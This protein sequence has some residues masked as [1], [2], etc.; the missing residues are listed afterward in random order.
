MGKTDDPYDADVVASLKDL[1]RKGFGA[2]SITCERDGVITEYRLE[3]GEI[4]CRNLSDAAPSEPALDAFKAA[5]E[6]EFSGLLP[7][8]HRDL[9]GKDVADL[10]GI[11]IA[12]RDGAHS[13]GGAMYKRLLERLDAE[14]PTPVCPTCKKRMVRHR[15]S[16]K[17]FASRLGPVAIERTYCHCRDCGS[18]FYPLLFRNC[19]DAFCG[20]LAIGLRLFRQLCP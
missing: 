17:S 4:Q 8:L 2:K 9:R 7:V 11:E 10:D 3:E 15:K 1:A 6:S 12:I 20:A 5:V 19:S 13:S 14:L 18:G 16:V